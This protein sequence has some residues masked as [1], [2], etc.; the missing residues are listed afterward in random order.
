[1][2]SAPSPPRWTPSELDALRFEGPGTDLTVG[3]LPVQPLVR[4]AL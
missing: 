3:L 4:G 1:M 2:T